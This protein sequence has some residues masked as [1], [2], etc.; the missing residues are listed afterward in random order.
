[1][2]NVYYWVKYELG[3]GSWCST[4]V[5][6]SNLSPLPRY[7][8]ELLN[9]H[10]TIS[11]QRAAEFQRISNRI[12]KENDGR[13]ITVFIMTLEI[14]CG[15]HLHMTMEKAPKMTKY[16]LELFD[17]MTNRWDFRRCIQRCWFSIEFNLKKKWLMRDLNI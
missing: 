9:A 13:W 2:R 8:M 16:C 7:W 15:L 3:S 4:K 6:L 5:P 17:K 11:W 12:P 14:I 1:M 10:H